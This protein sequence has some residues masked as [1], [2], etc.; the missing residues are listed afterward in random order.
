MEDLKRDKCVRM[1]MCIKTKVLTICCCSGSDE[2][3]VMEEAKRDKYV[4]KVDRHIHKQEYLHPV[5]VQV[6]V[7]KVSWRM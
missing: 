1:D 5:V 6:M 3:C 4:H 2:E 7:K